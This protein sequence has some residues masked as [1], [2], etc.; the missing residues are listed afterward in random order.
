MALKFKVESLEGMDE[1]T[2]AMYQKTDSGYQLAVDG[3]PEQEDT[4]GLKAKNAEL[5]A[6]LKEQ[7]AEREAADKAAREAADEAARKSGDVAAL[8]KSWSEK[9]TAKEAEL[10]A[11]IEA[12][13]S[14]LK[15]M[16]VD[17]VAQAMATEISVSP[18]LLIPH[19]KGRLSVEVQDG[20]HITRVLDAEGKPSAATID[21]L[22]KEFVSNEAYAPVIIGSKAS[23]GQAPS[24][25]AQGG[26][27]NQGGSLK[28]RASQFI[29]SKNWDN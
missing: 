12:R 20:K 16:L 25:G 15:T 22:K 23:G 29:K 18:A 1:A 7:K 9:L 26:G 5:L 8:E 3:L 14:S 6:K 10:M 4:S 28:D 13:D 11:Q 2:A 19:I 21:D 24:S 17:N 27:N